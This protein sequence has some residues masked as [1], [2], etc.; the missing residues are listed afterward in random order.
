MWAFFLAF[1]FCLIS[2][3][4]LSLVIFLPPVILP[5]S[6]CHSCCFARLS[7]TSAQTQTHLSSTPPT[8]T[9][10]PAQV[11][12]HSANNNVD[13]FHVP[14]LPQAVIISADL[15][16]VPVN[17]FHIFSFVNWSIVRWCVVDYSDVLDYYLTC[18]RRMN[19]PFQQ[20]T[21]TLLYKSC[22]FIKYFTASSRQMTSCPDTA[23]HSVCSW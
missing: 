23:V 14:C 5:H 19:S 15:A 18:S 3:S 22:G 2:L 12:C 20:V 1:L 21:W 7:V 10:A 4:L 13:F 6:P 8:S 17:C 11:Q 16:V 9:P